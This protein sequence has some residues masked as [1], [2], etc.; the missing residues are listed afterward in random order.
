MKDDLI[1]TPANVHTQEQ[2]GK[3]LNKKIPWSSFYGHVNS[4]A[5]SHSL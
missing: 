5:I 2:T 1:P 3:N 4:S